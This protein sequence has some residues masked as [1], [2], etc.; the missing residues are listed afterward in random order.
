M[1]AFSIVFQI[2][3]WLTPEFIL[4]VLDSKI[5]SAIYW[6]A[7]AV[8]AVIGFI[9][10]MKYRDRNLKRLLDAYVEKATKG[11]GRERQS[12]KSVIGRAMRKARGLPARRGDRTTFR[13]SDIFEDAA[14]LWAQR[15][16]RD[17]I[18]SLRKEAA[19]CESTVNYVKHQLRLAQ[20]RA[21]TAYLEIG[22]ILRDQNQGT[23][24]LDAFNA[25]L[26]VN[27]EDQDAL[28]MLGIQYRD[29]Q[30]FREA[31]QNFTT[32]LFYVQSDPATA[33]DI[34][35]ELAAVFVGSKEYQR[36]ETTLDEA[37]K[38]E[39]NRSNQRGIALTHESIGTV[40]TARS[41]WKQARRSYDDSKTIFHA[42]SDTE[43]VARVQVL[44]DRMEA[45]RSEAL[46]RRQQRRYHSQN[47]VPT[48]V[49]QP[50]VH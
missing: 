26:R 32:L 28:R 13:S 49:D 14:R 46:Q 25:M 22:S 6:G 44:T 5:F 38:I 27:P 1:Q 3:D 50:T 4:R 12:V 9:A 36:A 16:P 48:L 30:R 42:L 29:L 24:A 19:K 17:A 8:V 45:A 18:D 15:Q 2:P 20:E 31:E 21:A 35:R 41:R 7:A 23:E 34:K 37:M 40:Q 43:S 39:T 11:E 33:A 10:R 47:S